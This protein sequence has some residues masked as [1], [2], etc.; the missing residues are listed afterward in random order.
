MVEVRL[1]CATFL[2]HCDISQLGLGGLI[3]NLPKS[4]ICSTF[5]YYI[6]CEFMHE[7]IY[8]AVY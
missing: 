3:A 1:E 5:I 4:S 2:G 6:L 7:T 8:F